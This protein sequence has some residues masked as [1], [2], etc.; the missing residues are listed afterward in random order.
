[1]IELSIQFLLTV[2][3][4]LFMI[5]GVLIMYLIFQG[6]REAREKREKE[7]YTQDTKIYWQ[8]YFLEDRPLENK[9]IPKNKSEVA[10]IEN[11][12]LSYLKNISNPNIHLKIHSFAQIYLKAYYEK[13]LNSKR[14]SRRMNAMY[15]IADFQIKD[16]ISTCEVLGEQ[17]YSVETFQLLKIY[18][19]L[20]K[21]SFTREL[22]ASNVTFSES[23]YK[24]LFSYLEVAMLE[25]L[26]IK[27]E[28]LQKSAQYAL[29]DIISVKGSMDVI[30]SLEK[31][32]GNDNDEIR[33]RILKGLDRM[34]V[35]RQLDT[36]IPFVNSPI[37]EERLMVAKV[38]KHVPL[39][40]TADYLEI[41]LQD[42]N[43]WVRSQAASTMIE[44]PK[45]RQKL[46]EFIET[47]NDKYAIEMANEVL[48]KGYL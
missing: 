23:E 33:I 31:L 45:G 15:R 20:E 12:L 48:E 32:L 1:M 27:I 7:N 29:I 47:A 2:I 10:A 42:S 28:D 40:Y 37:W 35:I 30:E 13:E 24:K 8:E 38:F 22:L 18:S 44:D 41:L 16:L 34:G 5:C 14:W 36:F 19:I 26:I 9:L 3:V 21:E 17:K 11:I 39:T 6:R 25:Q 46:K 4:V 43:W